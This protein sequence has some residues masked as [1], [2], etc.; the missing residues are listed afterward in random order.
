MLRVAFLGALLLL[1]IGLLAAP[2]GKPAEE[3]KPGRKALPTQRVNLNSASASELEQLPGIG[4]A[5]A[6][7]IIHHRTRNGPFRRLEELL[8]IRGISRTK[9][10]RLRPHIRVS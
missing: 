6:R 7:A 5:T 8:I 10:N 2:R 9:L 3:S 4:P 1:A